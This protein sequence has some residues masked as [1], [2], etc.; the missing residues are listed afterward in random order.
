MAKKTT[1]EEARER[2]REHVP[3]EVL[4]HARA[5]QREFRKS[6]E[7]LFPP[8]FIEHRRAARREALLAVR[9]MIDHVLNRMDEGPLD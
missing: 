8:G 5:A 2:W 9:S 3:E 4:E 1:T 7:S 6:F